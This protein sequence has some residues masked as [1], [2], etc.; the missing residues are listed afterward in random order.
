MAVKLK[1]SDL[2]MSGMEL[3]NYLDGKK[4]LRTVEL[5]VP[6]SALGGP[7]PFELSSEINW[8]KR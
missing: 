2:V 6:A 3:L 7:S 4:S 8:D 1:G 5:E